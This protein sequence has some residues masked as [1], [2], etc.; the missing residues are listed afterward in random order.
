MTGGGLT[1]EYAGDSF[2]FGPGETVTVGRGPDCRL[3]VIDT[4]VSRLHATLSHDGAGWRL[5][6]ESTNGCWTTGARQPDGPLRTPLDLRLGHPTEGP[7]LTLTSEARGPRPASPVVVGARTTDLSTFGPLDGAA[8]EPPREPVRLRDGLTLGRDPGND[9]VLMDALVSRRHVRIDRSPGGVYTV[10]DLD[11]TNHAFVNGASVAGSASLRDGD[12][13]TVGRIR[14]LRAGERLFPLPPV[15]DNGLAVSDLHH[16]TSEGRSLISGLTIRLPGPSLLAVIGPA[17]TGK[18]TLLRLLSGELAPASGE[19]R[20]HDS[21]VTTSAEI[22]TFIGVVPGVPPSH[23]GLTVLEA[24]SFT[25]ALRLPPGPSHRVHAVLAELSLTDEAHTRVRDLPPHFRRL[26]ALAAELLTHPS[27]LLL[28]DPTAGLDPARSHHVMRLLRTLA[29]GNRQIVIATHDLTHLAL[30]DHTLVLGPG[31]REIFQGPTRSL[32]QM[33]GATPWPEIFTRIASTPTPPTPPPPTRPIPPPPPRLRL[34]DPSLRR[35]L[36]S[37]TRT[38]A[39]RDLRL[40]TTD[41]PALLLVAALPVVLA[42]L[43]IALTSGSTVPLRTSATLSAFL[44]STLAPLR[45]LW[46]ASSFHHHERTAGLLPTASSLA[47]FLTST[48]TATLQTLLFLTLLLPFRPALPLLPLLALP[49][50]VIPL[51]QAL[52]TPLL[53]R[54]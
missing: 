54:P 38:L 32:P 16:V 40:L 34:T 26:F 30:T 2:T 25:A 43:T 9:V 15:R 20:Y 50:A 23:G 10:A 48:T 17:G 6:D 37:Q 3:V 39:H 33:F 44:L 8:E 27:L 12:V 41:P 36:R 5:T 24:L 29:D 51:T 28:D 11:A 7:L 13:L 21:D 53:R 31:G 4:R 19:V 47:T 14:L 52:T 45:S 46:S 22:R 18:S 35:K 49:L 1:I 42:T